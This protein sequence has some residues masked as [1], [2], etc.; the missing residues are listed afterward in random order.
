MDCS[1]Q[2]PLSMGT[3]QARVLEELPCPP[4]RDLPNPETEPGSPT[5]QADSLPSEWCSA[6]TGRLI[7]EDRGSPGPSLFFSIPLFPSP[8]VATAL[9][10]ILLSCRMENRGQCPHSR[11]WMRFS[12][13]CS[14]C[15]YHLRISEACRWLPD[16]PFVVLRLSPLGS[17][18]PGG[19]GK[20]SS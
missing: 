6:I 10:T 18:S 4:P 13:S 20:R 8:V 17:S 9:R 7:G 3:L 2:A 5:L 15:C 14:L 1:L 11:E 19:C 12:L 16:F